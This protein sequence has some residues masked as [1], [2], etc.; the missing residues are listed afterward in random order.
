MRGYQIVFYGY[1]IVDLI[2]ATGSSSSTSGLMS[3]ITHSNIWKT[4]QAQPCDLET[5]PTSPA[6][7]T[8]S[9]QRTRSD[10]D[11][12]MNLPQPLSN[13]DFFYG[14]NNYTSI[15]VSNNLNLHK[16]WQIFQQTRLIIQLTITTTDK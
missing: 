2:Q 8:K 15:R 14:F 13:F 6:R 12:S 1:L 16:T 4:C 3:M 9:P 5:P 10:H 11:D 7:R